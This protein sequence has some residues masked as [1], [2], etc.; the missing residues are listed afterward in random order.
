LT[1]HD[2]NSTDADVDNIAKSAI[3]YA[4]DSTMNI[5]AVKDYQE[6]EL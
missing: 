5:F 6:I 4:A 2:P 3:E 1:H